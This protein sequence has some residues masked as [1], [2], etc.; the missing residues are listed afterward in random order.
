MEIPLPA[1]PIFSIT[2]HFK[3]LEGEQEGVCVWRGV[4]GGGGVSV[5]EK[6]TKP[7][8]GPNSGVIKLT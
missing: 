8:T 4:R 7:E 1:S 2:S 3:G 5:K 6:E